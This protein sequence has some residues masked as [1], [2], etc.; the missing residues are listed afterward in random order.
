MN[1]RLMMM[2][3]LGMFPFSRAWRGHSFDS[4]FDSTLILVPGFGPADDGPSLA[5]LSS[6]VLAPCYLPRDISLSVIFFKVVKWTLKLLKW[7]CT[8]C[9]VEFPLLPSVV[10]TWILHRCTPPPVQ[11]LG[12]TASVCYPASAPVLHTACTAASRAVVGVSCCSFSETI[13]P[14]QPFYVQAPVMSHTFPNL[15]PV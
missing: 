1:D 10:S 8:H 3:P 13:C 9:L 7:L 11:T 4:L 6:Y 12:H 5:R 14:H 2:T 15:P